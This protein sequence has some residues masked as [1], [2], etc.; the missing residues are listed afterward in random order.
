MDRLHPCGPFP[1]HLLQRDGPEQRK[2]LPAPGPFSPH[3]KTDQNLAGKSLEAHKNDCRLSSF[4][5]MGQ[6]R[7]N[8]QKL[9]QLY[10]NKELSIPA[11][12]NRGQGYSH[13]NKQRHSSNRVKKDSHPRASLPEKKNKKIKKEGS[14]HPVL[15]KEVL[16]IL[17]KLKP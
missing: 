1:G 3:R 11:K 15:F 16:K 5:A 13:P 12:G 9:S 6:E 7:G 8:T 17:V 2:C 14:P 4:Y 10:R